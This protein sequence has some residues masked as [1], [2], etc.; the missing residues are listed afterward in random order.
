LCAYIKTRI[1]GLGDLAKGTRGADFLFFFRLILL[2]QSR[3]SLFQRDAK[4]NE[5]IASVVCVD[6]RFDLC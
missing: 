1:T 2:R 5:R 4:W 3:Q 6:P